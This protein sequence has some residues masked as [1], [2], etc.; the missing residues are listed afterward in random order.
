[1]S[2]TYQG[3]YWLRDAIAPF[4]SNNL[5]YLKFLR[6]VEESTQNNFLTG[7][8]TGGPV[9]IFREPLSCSRACR[10]GVG[11][12]RTDDYLVGV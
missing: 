2:V 5:S 9:F 1:M 7:R 11:S 12:G 10:E 8:D 6:L 4:F 3:K